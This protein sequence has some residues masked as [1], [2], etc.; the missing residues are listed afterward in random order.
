LDIALVRGIV[1]RAGLGEIF[2]SGEALHNPVS[3]VWRQAVAHVGH[4]REGPFGKR[5]DGVAF[6]DRHIDHPADSVGFDRIQ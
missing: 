6:G 3:Q 5:G 4:Q 1:R 2:Q